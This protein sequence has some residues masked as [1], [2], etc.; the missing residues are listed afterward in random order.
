MRFGRGE[1]AD[2]R[3]SIWRNQTASPDG[4]RDGFCH[5]KSGT[6]LR[7]GYGKGKSVT[8]TVQGGTVGLIIDARGRPIAIPENDSLRAKKM[9][10]W[11]GSIGLA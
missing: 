8:A 9:R 11:M 2:N 6:K 4:R 7:Y 1:W 5:D 3:G 10:E